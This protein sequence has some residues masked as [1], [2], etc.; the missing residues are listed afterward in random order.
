MFN[1]EEKKRYRQVYDKRAIDAD[2]LIT[3]PYGYWLK[4]ELYD[5]IILICIDWMAHDNKDTY[6][7]VCPRSIFILLLYWHIID[8][9]P[10]FPYN[11]GQ[12]W[13]DFA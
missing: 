3:Y 7:R 11:V 9:K 12:T 6:I 8:D 4:I 10:L 13:K 5:S 2:T 1:G